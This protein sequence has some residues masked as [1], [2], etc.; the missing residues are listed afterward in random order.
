MARAHHAERG[1]PGCVALAATRAVLTMWSGDSG[2][3]DGR[4]PGP[5][6]GPSLGTH[7]GHVVPVVPDGA[8]RPVGVEQ[9]TAHRGIEVRVGCPPG[10]CPKLRHDL[11]DGHL[12]GAVETVVLPEP[13]EPVRSLAVLSTLVR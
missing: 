4:S 5:A 2:W 7:L 1:S 10:R 6:R 12:E 8:H 11:L 9:E 3:G 13:H